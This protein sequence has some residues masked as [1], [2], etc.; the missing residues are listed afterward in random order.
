M[1]LELIFI[2]INSVIVATGILVEFGAESVNEKVEV[3]GQGTRS[4]SS[5]LAEILN[6]N[7]PPKFSKRILILIRIFH[8]LPILLLQIP[9]R[10]QVVVFVRII[11]VSA[12]A[13]ATW[14]TQVPR[15]AVLFSWHLTQLQ[16]HKLSPSRHRHRLLRRRSRNPRRYHIN[17]PGTQLIP[18]PPSRADCPS[19]VT[20]HWF[21]HRCLLRVRPSY[22]RPRSNSGNPLRFHLGICSN[23]VSLLSVPRVTDSDTKRL[24]PLICPRTYKTKSSPFRRVTRRTTSKWW[25]CS[26]V[27]LD[28]WDSPWNAHQT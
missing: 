17:R 11:L 23:N 28:A 22:L 3:L 15:L 20:G 27:S 21:R 24:K 2:D 26:T 25:V 18:T 19:F 16:R 5:S 12:T 9:I 10:S 7:N 13:V 4:S 8:P 6:N 14:G 1:Y